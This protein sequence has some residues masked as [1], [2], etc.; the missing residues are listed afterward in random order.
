MYGD[1]FVIKARHMRNGYICFIADNYNVMYK[2]KIKN[3]YI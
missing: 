2:K 3:K 1:G